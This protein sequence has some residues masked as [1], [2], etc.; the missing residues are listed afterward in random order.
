[1]TTIRHSARLSRRALLGGAAGAGATTIL[2]ACGAAGGN[3]GGATTATEIARTG[4]VVVVATTTTLLQDFVR[5]IGGDRVQVAGILTAGADPHDYEPTAA[6]A[7]AIARADLLVTHGAGLDAWMDKLIATANSRAPR[8]VATSGLMLLKGDD[9]AFAGGDPHVWHD[10]SL[11]KAICA[12]IADSLG[13]VD[14]AHAAQYRQHATVYGGQLDALDAMLRVRYDTIP[15][16]GRKLVTN[17]DAFQYLARRYGFTVVG[18]VIP[19]LSDA[20]EPSA[21]D[22][23]ALIATIKREGVKAIFAET[24]ANPRV[25]EQVAREAGIRI[26]DT[27]YADSLGAPGGEADTYLKMME[28]NATAIVNALK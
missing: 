19:S 7:T 24:Q 10:P 12:T 20:A 16:A 23:S 4:R 1:M 28:A 22:I 26:V 2:G 6:D 5:N 13:R 3:A 17:H 27:L 8:T 21:R 15:A 9:A 18:A 11:V 14:A 25:A